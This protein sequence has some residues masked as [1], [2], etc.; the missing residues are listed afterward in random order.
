VA[1]DRPIDP[2]SR[3]DGRCGLDHVREHAAARCGHAF[4]LAHSHR[5]V[6]TRIDDRH[7]GIPAGRWVSSTAASSPVRGRFRLRGR[8]RTHAFTW[9]EQ[10]TF[11]WWMGG[12]FGAFAAKPVLRRVWRRNLRHL[13]HWS[14]AGGRLKSGT[15]VRRRLRPRR[16][17]H[18][19][20]GRDAPIRFS[21]MTTYA[22]SVA[23]IQT[24]AR[25]DARCRARSRRARLPLG[26]GRRSERAEAMVLLGA[27]SQA[28]R[29]S[30]SH[31]CARAPVADATAARDGRRD[32]ATARRRSRRVPRCRISSPA[33]AGQWTAPATPTGRSRRCASSSHLSASASPA[34][35]SPSRVT[36]IRQT[37][38]LGVRLGEHRPNLRAR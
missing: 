11:P 25:S 24:S 10:L 4:R 29:I 31:R 35:R 15:V 7:R 20:R 27:I 32:A 5:A 28:A 9:T 13:K 17:S 8:P 12:T 16:G 36:S 38:R 30:G 21:T 6:R 3:L 14:K 1:R 26:V 23:G 34:R 33:V 19:S 18:P 2:S 22:M 37:F